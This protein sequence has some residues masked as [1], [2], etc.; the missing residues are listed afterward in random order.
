MAGGCDLNWLFIR[1]KECFWASKFLSNYIPMLV[2]AYRTSL[3]LIL[4]MLQ[5]SLT[6]STRT[7]FLAGYRSTRLATKS[8]QNFLKCLKLAID[9]LPWP[10]IAALSTSNFNKSYY[11]F[12]NSFGL[13]AF[14]FFLSRNSNKMVNVASSSLLT[15]AI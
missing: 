6:I 14:R 3:T 9:C 13:L 7:S 10:K 11:A 5:T 12:D 2:K 4:E 1:S 8:L 15:P